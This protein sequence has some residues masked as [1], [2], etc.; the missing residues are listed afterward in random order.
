MRAP[1]RPGLANIVGI[2]I[3]T[4]EDVE[5]YDS[6]KRVI[7]VQQDQRFSLSPSRL[8]LVG[9]RLRRPQELGQFPV[10]SLGSL[11]RLNTSQL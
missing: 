11:A 3:E 5:A 9:F 2:G 10:M 7:D 1:N 8:E 4:G 6:P